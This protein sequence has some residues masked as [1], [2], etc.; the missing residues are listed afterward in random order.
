LVGEVDGNEKR[1]VRVVWLYTVVGF[2]SVRW[3]GKERRNRELWAW[4]DE[5]EGGET[6][7]VSI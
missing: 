4:E 2:A 1:R 7:G 6:K 3:R 5:G